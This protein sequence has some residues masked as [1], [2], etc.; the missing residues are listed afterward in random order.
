MDILAVLYSAKINVGVQISLQ[1]I[2]LLPIAHFYVNISTAFGVW[3][4][5]IRYSSG[6][7]NQP[8]YIVYHYFITFV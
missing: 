4:L 2:D 3:E 7:D 1:P 8:S 5:V 6:N